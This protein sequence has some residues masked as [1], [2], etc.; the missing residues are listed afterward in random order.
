MS[1]WS[2]LKYWIADKLFEDELDEA[3]EL[4]IREGG[5]RKII[6]AQAHLSKIRD[7]HSKAAQGGIDAANTVL[8]KLF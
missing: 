6:Q 8:G 1:R 2:E 4:G 5:R 7:D 3:F